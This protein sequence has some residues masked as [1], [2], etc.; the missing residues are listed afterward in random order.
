VSEEGVRL[1]FMLCGRSGLVW[2]TT[3]VMAEGDS[4]RERETKSVCVCFLPLTTNRQIL[5]STSLSLSLFF[6]V[7]CVSVVT[8]ARSL[9]FQIIS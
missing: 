2:L 6:F 3:A 1:C 5:F 4:P 9:F 7:R 8:C